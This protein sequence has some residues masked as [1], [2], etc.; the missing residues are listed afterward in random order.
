MA[1]DFLPLTDK[2]IKNCEADLLR[3]FRIEVFEL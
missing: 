1:R 3:T 2:M